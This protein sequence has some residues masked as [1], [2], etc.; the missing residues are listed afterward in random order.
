MSGKHFSSVQE[1]KIPLDAHV[2]HG[3]SSVTEAA[4][5][6]ESIPR[7]K[8]EGDEIYAGTVNEEGALECRV[9]KKIR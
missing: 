4:I 6:G 9:T 2:T 8:E 5:T 3:S 1:K 7:L